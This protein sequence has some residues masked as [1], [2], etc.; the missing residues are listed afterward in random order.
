MILQQREDRKIFPQTFSRFA[1]ICSTVAWWLIKVNCSHKA[2]QKNVCARTW[3]CACALASYHCGSFFPIGGFRYWKYVR[4]FDF[5][6]FSLAHFDFTATAIY[7]NYLRQG[8]K[9]VTTLGAG[10]WFSHELPTTASNERSNRRHSRLSR[11]LQA[12]G[13]Y[14]VHNFATP[15]TWSATSN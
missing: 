13:Y 6:S 15:F 12:E 9:R 5:F 3:F 10:C 7:Y 11:H 1:P 4:W 2:H 8:I 14:A